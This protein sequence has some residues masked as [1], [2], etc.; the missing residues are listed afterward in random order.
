VLEVLTDERAWS[1]VVR[2]A[3][4]LVELALKA[5]LR[6]VGIDP[7]KWH[8]VGPILV[9]SARAFPEPFTS[10]IPRLAE[11]SRWLR[12][13]R[14][15]A[16]YGDVDLVPT[17]SYHE[18]DAARAMADAFEV[19]AAIEALMTDREA[20]RGRRTRAHRLTGRRN[21]FPTDRTA[22]HPGSRLP[23]PFRSRRSV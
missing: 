19:Y 22:C 16:F 2:E 20:R 1:D 14:E 9:E 13:E 15:L 8:D 21:A 5:A 4:E 18:G 6:V 7:P 17:E 3:Q 23:G 10:A 12:R 11:I